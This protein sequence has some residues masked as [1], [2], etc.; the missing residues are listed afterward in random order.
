MVSMYP[1]GTV[2]LMFTDIEGST[3]LWESD[4]EAMAYALHRHD[5]LVREAIEAAGGLVFKTVGDGFCA[6]FASA[7]SAIE[8]AT[9]AQR[10]LSAQDWKLPVPIRVR[11]ALHSGNCEER[12]GDYFGP[13]V[14]RA[15]R[16]VGIAHGGQILLSEATAALVRAELI[17]SIRDLG[18]H[19][20]KDLA[21]PQH[22]FQLEVDDTPREFPPLASLNLANLPVQS[23]SLVGRVDEL[24]EVLALLHS[25]RL[26]TLTGAGGSGKTK[27]A[28]QAAAE[29]VEEFPDGVWFVPLS[30]IRDAALLESAI[31]HALGTR[32]ELTDFLKFKRILLLLDNVEQLLPTAATIVAELLNAP[33]VKVLATSRERLNVTGEQQY[34]VP[35]LSVND[36]VAL[37]AERARQVKPAFVPDDL[38]PLIVERLDGLPLA[39]ELAAAQTRVLATD[40]LLERLDRRLPVLTGG[41]RDAPERQRALSATIAWSYE[42]LSEADKRLF[43]RLAVFRGSFSFESAEHVCGA[44]IDTLASLVDKSLLHETREGR[45]FFLGTIHEYALDQL[46]TTGGREQLE[47]RRAEYFLSFCEGGDT[48]SNQLEWLRS[49][50][51]DYPNLRETLAWSMTSGDPSIALR[52]TATLGRFWATRGYLRDG[53]RWFT[54][55]LFAC[56]ADTPVRA[57]ALSGAALLAALQGDW[58]EATR[59][60]TECRELSVRT[61]EVRAA[62]R[63]LLTLGR[64]QLGRGAP[65]DEVRS[66]FVQA[67]QEAMQ[68]GA[69]DVAAFASFNLGY[70]ALSTCD[71]TQAQVEFEDAKEIFGA[72]GDTFGIC[73]TLAALGSVALHEERIADAI[74]QLRQCL[75]MSR[76]LLDWD[77][78]AWALEL[79]AIALAETETEKVIRILGAAEA[80]REMLGVSLSGMELEMHE[81]ALASLR[82]R[83]GPVEF[84]T[85]WDAG[86]RLS[87]DLAVDLALAET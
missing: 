8:A 1:S 41:P 54:N 34:P 86:R 16:L 79:L 27:L 77:D 55:A 26:L 44:N 71:Y 52:L 31:S 15:A 68:I 17:E 65:V 20:L 40:N 28:L 50:E 5:T 23:S 36:A 66:L 67:R 45:F 60:S 10:A 69:M 25:N 63:S 87:P 32:S 58:S 80:Q 37:F 43:E 82:A 4:R 9:S 47:R 38:V 78:S 59:F 21:E 24:R 39:V 14:N 49:L 12:D 56:R 74:C 75:T 61:G 51:P 18:L 53:R 7:E 46:D 84:T 85:A 57:N 81:R 64:A 62:A 76:E 3:R 13:V 6:A 73:R 19:R 35:A 11:M 83:V 22:I 33:G 70:A 30:A 48:A 29:I 42:L 72:S 2:T